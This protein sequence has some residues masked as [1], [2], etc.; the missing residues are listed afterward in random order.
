ML[1]PDPLFLGALQAAIAADSRFEYVTMELPDHSTVARVQY[2]V[3]CD[4]A[5]RCT[6]RDDKIGLSLEAETIPQFLWPA[7]APLAEW[8][9]CHRQLFEG[10]TVLELGSGVGLAG[11][12]A[13]LFAR[14][15]VLTDC[16]PVSLA[17]LALSVQRRINA[18]GDVAVEFLKWGDAGAVAELLA[19]FK[20]P[21]F[22]VVIGCDIFYFNASLVAGLQSARGALVGSDDLN[23]NALVAVPPG[24]EGS[25]LL[26]IDGPSFICASLARSERMDVDIDEVPPRCGFCGGRVGSTTA[27]GDGEGGGLRIYRWFPAASGADSH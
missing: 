16:A 14:L 4:R 8:I 20:I 2:L 25:D 15:V 23:S 22:D 9:V 12:T 6:D 26:A 18:A 10:R 3:R 21:A 1:A 24:A 19:K 27:V 7:A 5:P 13:A 17:M 11:L